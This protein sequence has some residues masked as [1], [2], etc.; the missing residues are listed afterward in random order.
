MLLDDFSIEMTGKDV[1]ALQDAAPLL[2]A[3]TRVSVTYLGNETASMRVTAA[4]TARRLGFVPV[5]HV[6]ARRLRSAAELEEFLSAL[7]SEASAKD[8]VVVGG[9]PATSAGPYEDA[10]AVMRTGLLGRYGFERVSICG[11]PEGHPRISTDRLWQALTD[12]VSAAHELGLGCSVL[13]QF[14]FAVEPVLTWLLELRRRGIDLPVRVG[15]PGPTG[16]RRLLSYARRFGVASSTAVLQKYPL[17]MTSLLGSAGPDRFVTELADRYDPAVHG[18]VRMHFY[19]FGGIE[20]TA[21]WAQQY[22]LG[23]G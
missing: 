12:K 13:T 16:V 20:A 2:P 1:A 17:S 7:A 5:P 3:G 21:R 9:D 14:G 22:R 23:A 18:A 19:T 10:L 8:L 6:C 11:Y 4:R 15:V